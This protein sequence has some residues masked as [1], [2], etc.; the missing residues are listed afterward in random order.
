MLNLANNHILDQGAAGLENTLRVA[1]AAGIATVGA[2]RNQHEARRILVRSLSGVRLGILAVA[3]HEF[4]TAGPATPGAN[5]LDLIDML[6]NI[7]AH[8]SQWDYLVVLLHGG[9]EGYPFPSPRLQDTCR[10][11]VEQGAGAVLCQH[12]HCVGCYEAYRGG[13][14]LYGQ[15]NFVF[16]WPD[17]EIPGWNQGLLVRLNIS[18]DGSSQFALVPIEQTSPQKPGVQEMAPAAAEALLATIAERSKRIQDADFVESTWRE[19]CHQRKQFCLDVTLCHGRILRRLNRYGHVVKWLYSRGRLRGL[20][21]MVRCEAT[22]QVL[23]TVLSDI[24]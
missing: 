11:L 6:R 13:H 7:S 9:N 4:S 10:F 20:L 3:Q 15:G 1:E 14:I 12:T 19:F 2:G 24:S 22:A 21:N 8:R 23:E 18:D 16:N 5:P 17:P